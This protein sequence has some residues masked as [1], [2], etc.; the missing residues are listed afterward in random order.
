MM[1]SK[2]PFCPASREH[3]SRF[4][5][6]DTTSAVVSRSFCFV[7]GGLSSVSVVSAKRRG[8]WRCR[9]RSFAQWR[10]S[11]PL[12]SA[13]RT[14]AP[15]A[16]KSEASQSDGEAVISAAVAAPTSCV[17]FRHGQSRGVDEV[18]QFSEVDF[19]EKKRRR[20]FSILGMLF[21]MVTYAIGAVLFVPLLL[22]HPFVL[23]LDRTKRRFHQFI[24]MSWLRMTL[25]S[26]RIRPQV[27]NGHN[28]PPPGTT[29]VY[30]A[31]HSSNMDVYL[32]PFLS[33]RLKVVAKAEI[34]RAPIIG[35]AIQM[36]GN[37]GVKRT[38]RRARMEAFRQMVLTLQ[39]GVSLVVFPEGTRS[40]S[41]RLS[42]FQLGAFRAAKSANVPVVPVTITGTREMMPS[43][44]YVPLRYPRWPIKL[45]VHP[46][47][48]SI[49]RTVE[50]LRDLAFRAVDST[51]DVSLRSSNQDLAKEGKVC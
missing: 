50:E 7:S 38:D 8:G 21:L 41:G 34:F 39:R 40:E 4:A 30:V 15:P 2:M 16:D 37:I 14:S 11:I 47:I 29:V 43:Y 26:I 10:D 36:A 23:L 49:G 9:P 13:R 44:A 6:A 1:G 51:L 25:S 31:N 42:R 28:L 45:T 18:M 48:D 32:I 17:P 24:G 5:F 33:H 27:V 22:A 19:R 35:W 46:A 20:R 3:S 12:A